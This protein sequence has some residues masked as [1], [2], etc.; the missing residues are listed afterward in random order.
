MDGRSPERVQ[1]LKKLR[2]AQG[3]PFFDGDQTMA[4]NFKH[5][6]SVAIPT[7]K[8][9]HPSL[10]SK[11]VEAYTGGAITYEFLKQD[12]LEAKANGTSPQVPFYKLGHRTIKYSQT[13]LDVFLAASRVS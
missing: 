7:T 6:K 11:Q 10:T 2:G 13:D 9:D 5:S 4:L 3:E 8:C 1:L 12:R